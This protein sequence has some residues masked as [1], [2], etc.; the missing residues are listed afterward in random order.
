MT[1]SKM[2]VEAALY[3]MGRCKAPGF[4]AP[5]EFNI[6]ESTNDIGIIAK[7]TTFPNYPGGDIVAFQ[8][9]TDFDFASSMN[10]SETI[11]I[12]TEK[13]KKK[14]FIVKFVISKD[15]ILNKSLYE[16]SDL[17][18]MHM[19]RCVVDLCKGM[20]DDLLEC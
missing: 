20:L 4:L 17:C 5:I 1:T 9:V 13:F 19:K 10:I 11:S 7:I 14:T 15:Q 12:E 16:I 8:K 3:H 6:I 2:A 18:N